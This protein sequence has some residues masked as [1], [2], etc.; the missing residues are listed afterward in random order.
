[1]TKAYKEYLLP[2][3]ADQL[4][5]IEVTDENDS[6]VDLTDFDKIFLIVYYKD[7]EILQKFSV[8][9]ESGYNGAEIGGASNNELSFRL[10]SAETNLAKE[11]ILYYEI[12]T[13]IADAGSTDDSIYDSIA[14]EQY[15][16][17]ITKSITS[18]LTLP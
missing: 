15:L 1:M 2:R 12:R 7:R 3:G 5:T 18:G 14:T 8:T 10:L 13:Q 11:G 6:A 16:C 17:T 4:F 9:T